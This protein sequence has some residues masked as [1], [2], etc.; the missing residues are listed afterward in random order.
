[1]TSVLRI[2]FSSAATSLVKLCRMRTW[3]SKSMTSITSSLRSRRAKPIAAS[4]AVASRSFMLALV[5]R[6]IASAIGCCTR[7]KK[8]SALTRAVLVDLEVARLRSL[9]YFV[10]FH[11]RDVERHEI[12]AAAEAPLRL[13]RCV[14]GGC[15]AGGCGGDCCAGVAGGAA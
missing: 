1:M 8:D 7:E 13:R 5:S 4:C 10:A 11:H 2:A 6:R 12:D 3:L 9:T 15:V 14:G